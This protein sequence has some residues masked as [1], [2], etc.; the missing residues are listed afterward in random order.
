MERGQTE[1]LAKINFPWT[2][3]PEV[4]CSRSNYFILRCVWEKM[5]V[6]KVYFLILPWEYFVMR[7]VEL[8]EKFW[9]AAYP[10]WRHEPEQ[11]SYAAMNTFRMMGFLFHNRAMFSFCAIFPL[12][13][14]MIRTCLMAWTTVL[15]IHLD[16]PEWYCRIHVLAGQQN[17]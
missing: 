6:T 10:D 15:W 12:A 2:R 16:N 17:V 14:Y 3:I 1:S 8:Y 13:F 4:Y 9:D 5:N 11:N 7:S